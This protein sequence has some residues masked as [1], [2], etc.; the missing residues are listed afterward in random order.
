[1]LSGLARP[2]PSRRQALTA[3]WSARFER[4]TRVGPC[5][6][7]SSGRCTPIFDLRLP[8]GIR[9]GFAVASDPTG[10]GAPRQ[11]AIGSY[12]ARASWR[13]VTVPMDV[14]R[15]ADIVQSVSRYSGARPRE[16]DWSG[17]AP[18]LHRMALS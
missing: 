13:A 10:T 15:V 14:H 3:G 9:G 7:P 5:P 8:F 11:S 6:E 16:H 12:L 2:P 4:M 18:S 1:M 17:L